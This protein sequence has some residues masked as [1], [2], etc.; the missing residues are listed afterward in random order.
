MKEKK[1]AS[2]NRIFVNRTLN[3]NSIKLV[4]FD[5]D[6]TLATY[7][8]PAFE[9]KA[10]EIVKEKLVKEYGYPPEIKSLE[11]DKDFII[12]GLVID[13]ETG[14]FL[15][16][17]RYGFVRTA[18]HGTSFFSFE[19]QKELFGT[20]CID[21]TDPR[22]YIVH[23]LFSLAEGGIYAQ[24]IDYFEAKNI[25][26]NYRK[27]FREVRKSLNDSHQEEEL[28]GDVIKHPEKYLI[29]DKRIVDTLLKMRKF[30]KKIALITN[31]DYHYSRRVM[32]YCFEPFLDVPWQ[33][34]FDLI[35]VAANKPN[36]FLQRQNFLRV[37]RETGLLSNFYGK[38]EWNGIYQGGNAPIIEKHLGISPQEIL[39]LGDHILGDVVTLKETIGWRTGLVVQ[40]LAEEVPILEKTM[41]VHARIAEKMQMK[42]RLEDL[43]LDLREKLYLKEG[44]YNLIKKEYENLKNQLME[45]DDE[46][47]DLIFESQKGFNKYWGEI[48][49]AGNEISRFATLVER[50]ACIY[51]AGI[52]NFYYYSPFKYFRSQRRFLAHD[53]IPD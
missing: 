33:D 41:Q 47:R 4:G 23:T 29:Q 32:E 6:Y 53:P 18:S 28:K 5:M 13:T 3:M 44:D 34:I 35:I 1:V 15:K 50:Y 2:E 36:F 19:E 39:Y 45:L 9:T 10:Y 42:E 8:V 40:E 49:R 38:I 30:G 7:D 25:P 48:M 52:A 51:T 22:Y 37:D 12:R 11:F 27:L 31:S 26:I 46:I 43:S 16:V 24:L 14:N 20:D 21:L 17:N